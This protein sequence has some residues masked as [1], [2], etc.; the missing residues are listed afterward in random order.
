[1]DIKKKRISNQYRL[2]KSKKVQGQIKLKREKK[3]KLGLRL[4]LSSFKGTITKG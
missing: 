1:M 3:A 4:A 2:F